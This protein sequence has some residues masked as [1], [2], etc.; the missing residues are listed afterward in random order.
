MNIAIFVGSGNEKRKQKA[1]QEFLRRTI[2]WMGISGDQ[3]ARDGRA[4]A[5]IGAVPICDG[6]SWIEQS[7]SHQRF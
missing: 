1:P 3:L 4:D 2:G 6:G 5:A 7:R